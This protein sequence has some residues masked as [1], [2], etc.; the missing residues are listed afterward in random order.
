MSVITSHMAY[1]VDNFDEQAVETAKLIFLWD[2][3]HDQRMW[4]LMCDDVYRP[5]AR[6][7]YQW[8]RRV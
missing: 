5:F 8:K 6:S 3:E 4:D 1:N 7:D 2:A